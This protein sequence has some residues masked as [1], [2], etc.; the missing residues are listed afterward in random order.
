[1]SHNDFSHDAA[2]LPPTLEELGALLPQFEMKDFLA[3]GGMGAVY[4]ARQISLDRLVA[5]KVLPP[6]WGAEAG[7]AQL[8]QKEARAMA[9]LQHNQIVGVYDFGITAAGHFYLV[10]EYVQGQTLHDL[11]RLRRLPLPRVQGL[12][13]QLCDAVAFAHEQGVLHRDI[14]PG[15]V[16][17]SNL[18]EVKIADFGLA[19]H[20]GAEV[21]EQSLGTPDYAAPELFVQGA[22]VDHRADIYALGIVLQE[23]LTGVVPGRPREPLSDHG[24]YDPAWEP[25]IAKA[26]HDDPALRYHTV[27][28]LRE[29]VANV[30]RQSVRTALSPSA[31]RRRAPSPVS[32]PEASSFPWAP[33]VAG[34]A[35]IGIAAFWWVKNRGELPSAASPDPV[36]QPAAV[37]APATAEGVPSAAPEESMR[38]SPSPASAAAAATTSVAAASS[39][40]T[41]SA[42]TPAFKLGTAFTLDPMPPGHVFKLSEGHKDLIVDVAVFPD[43]RHVATGSADGTV[44]VWDLQS[45]TRVRTF[46]PMPGSMVRV[47]VSPDGRHVAAGSGEYKAYVWSMDDAPGTAPKELVTAARVVPHLLFSADGASLLLSTSESTQ[48]LAVW[49]WQTGHSE[50]IPG[51]RPT[52]SGLEFVPG[53]SADSFI[54]VGQR[55]D[56]N[57]F[58]TEVWLCD[59]ARRSLVKQQGA[60]SFLA[61]VTTVTPDGLR[62]VTRSRDGQIVTWDIGSG[63]TISRSG[64]VAP[65]VGDMHL[66]DGGRLVLFGAQDRCLHI[67]ETMTGREVWKSEPADTYCTNTTAVLSGGRYAI[68]GGGALFSDPLQKDGDFF[69]HVWALPDLSTL[70]SGEE[71]KALAAQQMLAIESNDPELWKLLTQLADGWEEKINAAPMAARQELDEKYLGALRREMSGTSPRDREAYLSEISRISNG[72]AGGLAGG[73]PTALIR[74]NG[75]YQQQVALLPQK[76]AATRDELRLAHQE[77]LGRLEK[78]R[79]DAGYTSAATRVQLVKQALIVLNGEMVLAKVQQHFLPKP[80]PSLVAGSPGST[81]QQQVTIPAYASPV[82]GLAHPTGLHRVEVWQRNV[83]TPQFSALGRVPEDLGP[84]VALAVGDR[85]A[86]ALRP[87]GTVVQWGHE[88]SKTLT[89]PPGVDRIVAVTAG[90]TL[91]ACLRDDGAVI[92]WNTRQLLPQPSGGKSPIVGISAAFGYV[93]ARHQ[94]GS[95]TYMGPNATTTSTAFTPPGDLTGCTQVCA[96]GGCAFALKNDGTVVGWGRS[97]QP[98]AY[99]MTDNMPQ[100]YLVNGISI[101]AHVDLGFMLNRSGELIAWGR[102]VPEEISNRP[103]FPGATRLVA[104]RP[105]TGLAI[106][107]QPGTWKFLSLSDKRFPIDIDTAERRSRG[108]TDIGIGLYYI[109]GLRPM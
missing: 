96:A 42:E 36:T 9:R 74:L 66:L 56:S 106:G 34:A 81:M 18:G 90:S 85:H 23:M 61:S 107:F 62:G 80:E 17:V 44:G 63:R 64:P 7:Y 72:G 103:R 109:L 3:K 49:Q 30:G 88:D 102:S 59:L 100:G 76:A 91:S 37:P 65:V 13:L 71:D 98:G 25:L 15:N 4:L 82:S 70:K 26:T 8:F 24:T 20:A 54:A 50:L 40:S 35:V 77:E 75:I 46:G 48:S 38:P 92:A 2:F 89:V 47:T 83:N 22:L 27:R 31:P 32:S 12:A 60:P 84:V 68:T 43:Q 29:T 55:V 99:Q 108:C 101:A 53:V 21:E 14:K 93:L 105:F 10:M 104:G 1:M 52:A 45:G 28:E 67:V 94:D 58:I 33:L 16:L 87:D 51:F 11:I 41:S 86:L 6:A 78:K 69:L 73:A 95:V 97:T 5:I 57:R 79:T 39:S 19:R